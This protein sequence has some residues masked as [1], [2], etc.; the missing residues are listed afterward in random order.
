[1][2]RAQVKDRV[3]YLKKNYGLT[4]AQWNKMFKLQGGV[5]P[6]CLKPIY[7]PHNKEGKA[8]AHVDHD[9][10]TKRVRGLLCW[11]CNRRRVGNNTLDHARRMVL[12]LESDFDGR[13]I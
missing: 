4:P 6:I 9:H 1:M 2:K 13:N 3:F 8:T 11:G 5:C 12:Y 7:K 10:R